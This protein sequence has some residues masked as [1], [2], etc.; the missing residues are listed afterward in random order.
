MD[1]GR[2]HDGDHATL[3]DACATA[4]A[5]RSTTRGHAPGV[6]V[7]LRE[8]V[9]DDEVFFDVVVELPSEYAKTLSS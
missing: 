1:C 2:V 9:R 8:L 5:S 6:F 4:R 3:H 7:A